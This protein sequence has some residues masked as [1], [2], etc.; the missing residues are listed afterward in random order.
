MEMMTM[1]TYTVEK[2]LYFNDELREFFIKEGEAISK[3]FDNKFDW[4]YA[5]YAQMIERG[6]FLVG[7][8]DTKICGF[9]ISYLLPSPLDVNVKLLQQQIFYV[10][11]DSGRMAYYLFKKFIDIGKTEANHII[12]M[13]TSKTNIKP[14][15]LKRWGFSELETLYRM[16]I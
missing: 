5:A 4:N 8:K 10:K 15:T 12:T 3:L 14:S 7:K 2:A 13:L 9:H 6:I 16:E 11:P 1:P